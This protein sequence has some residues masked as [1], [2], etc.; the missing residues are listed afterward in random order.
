VRACVC[1]CAHACVCVHECVCVCAHMC[2]CVCAHVQPHAC[3]CTRDGLRHGSP[4]LRASGQ[5]GAR[6]LH[7]PQRA[8]LGVGLVH[9]TPLDGLDEGVRGRPCAPHAAGR[10]ALRGGLSRGPCA[11]HAAR[12]GAL[13]GGLSSGRSKEG[14]RGNQGS[15]GVLSLKRG[16]GVEDQG[17][18]Y[19]LPMGHPPVWALPDIL[20]V[21]AATCESWLQARVRNVVVVV[22]A[23]VGA[24]LGVLA[25]AGRD[26]AAQTGRDG[27]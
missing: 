19:T 3:A 4:P 23:V 21:S 10:R 16:A 17:S 20:F 15:T 18:H 24:R 9:A 25:W 6:S 5:V 2:A 26:T 7:A 27:T 8:H 12:G 22:V 11:S 13:R 1:L 14:E